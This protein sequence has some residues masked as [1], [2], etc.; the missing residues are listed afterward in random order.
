[1]DKYDGY[2]DQVFAIKLTVNYPFSDVN[3]TWSH[4][5]NYEINFMKNFII[6]SSNWEFYKTKKKNNSKMSI[7]FSKNDFFPNVKFYKDLTSA[8]ISM[9]LEQS[10]EKTLCMVLFFIINSSCQMIKY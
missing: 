10:F 6:D 2:A 5:K 3:F 1:L 8:K 7:F 9:V 4:I